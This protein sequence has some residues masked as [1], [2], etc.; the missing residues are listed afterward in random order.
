V[1]NSGCYRSLI[2]NFITFCFPPPDYGGYGNNYD[3]GY[4]GGR[5]GGRGK[6]INLSDLHFVHCCAF[7]IV[8]GVAAW[9]ALVLRIELT[10]HLYILLYFVS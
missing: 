8:F 4:S 1:F 6:G 2:C 10:C 5:G 7:F 3:G 9:M